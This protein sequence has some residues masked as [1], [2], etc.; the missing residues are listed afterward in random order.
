MLFQLILQLA[1]CFAAVADF[2]LFLSADLRKGFVAKIENRIIA[3]TAVA[4]EFVTDFSFT[5][6]LD[7]DFAAVRQNTANRTGIMR[8]ALILRHPR[9]GEALR[10]ETPLPENFEAALAILR[11]TLVPAEKK[12]VQ[13]AAGDAGTQTQPGEVKPVQT[14]TIDLAAALEA[15]RSQWPQFRGS[16]LPNA[17]ALPANWDFQ[18]KWTSTK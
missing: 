9:T 15:E 11:A 4:D 1:Q 6:F 2:I 13:A 18:K 5:A 16:T 17:N 10:F 3:E 14:E 12:P 7:F 8:A